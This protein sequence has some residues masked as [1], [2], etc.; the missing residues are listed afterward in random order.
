MMENAGMHG[1]FL[2][3][4]PIIIIFIVMYFVLC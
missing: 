2:L 3:L 4:F 1:N